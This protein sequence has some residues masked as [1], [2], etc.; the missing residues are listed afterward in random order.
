MVDSTKVLCPENL[1]P[2]KSQIFKG[3]R[4]YVLLCGHMTFCA[5]R[6]GNYYEC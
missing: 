2:R 4:S 3:R 1:F 6:V 5:F